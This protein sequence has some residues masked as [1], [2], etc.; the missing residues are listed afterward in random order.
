[1][2]SQTANSPISVLPEPVGAATRTDSPLASASSASTW[3]GSSG[4]GYWA[5]NDA[6]TLRSLTPLGA[7]GTPSTS[8]TTAPSS[9]L[10]VARPRIC[11]IGTT[12]PDLPVS[13][14]AALPCG[15]LVDR[16]AV[17][18]AVLAGIRRGGAGL[19]AGRSRGRSRRG[20]GGCGRGLAGGGG[21]VLLRE[22]RLLRQG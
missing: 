10:P 20:G 15:P 7:I 3:N 6:A 19:R 17:T 21:H 16:G 12:V 5:A 14:P 9:H 13:P 22:L 4:K 1:M 18:A 8:F 2:A 11:P